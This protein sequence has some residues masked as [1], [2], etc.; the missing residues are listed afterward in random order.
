V[1][2]IYAALDCSQVITT[3]H[4][5]AALAIWDYCEASARFIFGDSLGDEIADALIQALSNSSVGMSRTEISNHF[6]R[7]K[8]AS[9]IERGLS[10]LRDRG[11][12]RCEIIKNEG[13]AE[14]RWSL[15]SE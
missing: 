13:R 9:E 3:Q 7:H 12:A 15:I 4:L 6:K 14:E 10:I 5:L 1:A 11:K 2:A 8:S